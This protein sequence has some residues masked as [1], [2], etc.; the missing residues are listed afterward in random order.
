MAHAVPSG[1]AA[2][3]LLGPFSATVG[4]LSIES[5]TDYPFGDSVTLTVSGNSAGAVP[6]YV[7]IP[8]W[9]TQATIS[10]NGGAPTAVGAANGTMYK[11]ELP[12]TLANNTVLLTLNPAIYVDSVGVLYNGAVTV[13][14]GALTY[15]MALG[16]FRNVTTRWPT[17][18]ADHP[19]LEDFT[20]NSTTPWNVAVIVDPAKADLT[21]FFTF[22][23][24]GPYNA[25][26]PWDHANPQLR[27]TAR[28]RQLPAWGLDRGAAAAPPAS[29]ACAAPGACGEPF[30]VTF[31]PYGMQHL[32]MAVLPWTPQ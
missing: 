16:E 12:P 5:D 4:D 28:A 18:A 26:Q 27:I 32:R 22:S 1:G 3:S 11:L 23:R 20:L 10:L 17:P 25:S 30:E 24:A 6:F 2:V 9:A 15:G 8:S 13:H 14:R 29:P 31:V 7:R 19:V 21:P